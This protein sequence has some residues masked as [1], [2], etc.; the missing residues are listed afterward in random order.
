MRNSNISRVLIIITCTMMPDSYAVING[1][2][3]AY[4]AQ[5]PLN[6]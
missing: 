3:R 5:P 2:E 6:N 1:G 4:V